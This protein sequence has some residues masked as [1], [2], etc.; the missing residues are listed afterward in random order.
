MEALDVGPQLTLGVDRHNLIKCL[1]M[2]VD[3]GKNPLK[4]CRCLNSALVSALT[5][6]VQLILNGGA[7]GHAAHA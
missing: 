4:P 3:T 1:V 5:V 6:G 2:Y 7:C